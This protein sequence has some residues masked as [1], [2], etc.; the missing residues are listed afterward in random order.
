MK[1]PILLRHVFSELDKHSKLHTLLAEIS[2][3]RS[4]PSH[5]DRDAAK[6]SDAFSVDFVL[7]WVPAPSNKS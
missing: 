5:G 1:P 6:E 7:T 2:K 4:K 3:Q